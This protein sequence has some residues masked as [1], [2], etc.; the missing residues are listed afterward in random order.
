[1]TLNPSNAK[2][3]DVV[4]QDQTC[5]QCGGELERLYFNGR[6][7]LVCSQAT[8]CDY[9]TPAPEDQQLRAQGAQ[10]LPGFEQ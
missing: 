10:P 8:D 2:K 3:F 6:L 9:S 1:M 7:H 5:P 4:R